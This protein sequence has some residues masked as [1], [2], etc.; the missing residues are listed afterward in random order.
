MGVYVPFPTIVNTQQMPSVF[1]AGIKRV[2]R[3]V[4]WKHWQLL[5][6]RFL[7]TS[8]PHVQGLANFPSLWLHN[9]GVVFFIFYTYIEKKNP[10]FYYGIIDK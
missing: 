10:Q 7:K 3:S 9:L 1:Q 2:L 4:R 8:F 5:S 6:H